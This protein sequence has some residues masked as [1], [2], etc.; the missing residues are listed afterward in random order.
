MTNA[1][2]AGAFMVIEMH[3]N[4]V[5]IF[6]K[7]DGLVNMPGIHMARDSSGRKLLINITGTY[8]GFLTLYNKYDAG[9][10]SKQ[11]ALNIRDS[12]VDKGYKAN[13]WDYGAVADDRFTYYLN[14]P[15]SVIYECGF[16]SHP[17]EEKE[18][19][20]TEYMD[21]MIKTQYE[22]LLK[23][24]NDIYGID[25]SKS[26]FKGK[27]KDYKS[28]IEILK[29]ARLAIYFIQNADT[30]SA[31]IAVKAMKDLYY[32]SRTKDSINYYTSIMS[33]I[34]HAEGYF[35]KGIKYRNKRKF[36]KARVCFVNAKESINRQYC[37]RHYS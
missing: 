3:M 29:L 14:F 4:N 19:L 26:E 13:S 37:K 31:N 2:N 24:F 8:S 34:N 36:N 9:G 20:K 25:I 27:R 35:Q 23:T 12:L 30:R 11:Y 6:S 28:G 1:K 16:I 33:T 22:M 17:Q 5:S 15:V 10:F 21:G 32:N 18:L 7:A